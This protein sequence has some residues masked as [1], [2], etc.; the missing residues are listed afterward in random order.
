VLKN[1]L[2]LSLSPTHCNSTW[3]LNNP[4][5]MTCRRTFVFFAIALLIGSAIAEKDVEDS[6]ES[7]PDG[8]DDS[9][10]DSRGESRLIYRFFRGK[11]ISQCEPGNTT[12]HIRLH[13]SQIYWPLSSLLACAVDQISQSS[14]VCVPT[15][16]ITQLTHSHTHTLTNQMTFSLQNAF[17]RNLIMV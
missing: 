11:M 13:N 15:Y 10:Y 6:A 2:S 14:C 1:V 8:D 17:S 5:I 12:C 16:Q 3:K 4:L 7:A 9:F